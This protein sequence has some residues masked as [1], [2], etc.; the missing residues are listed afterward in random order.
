MLMVKICSKECW[1]QA[2]LL[3]HD[4][5][6]NALMYNSRS[7]KNSKIVARSFLLEEDLVRSHH[8]MTIFGFISDDATFVSVEL[9][10]KNHKQ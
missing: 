7:N 9:I 1:L 2:E 3:K 5:E 10:K 8:L 4:K 6:L